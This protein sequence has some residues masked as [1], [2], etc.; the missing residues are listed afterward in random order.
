MTAL[1]RTDKENFLTH[2]ELTETNKALLFFS[3]L[4]SN[5]KIFSAFSFKPLML[6]LTK[7]DTKRLKLS[8]AAFEDAAKIEL[9]RIHCL[10]LRFHA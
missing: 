1:A 4:G 5:L 6:K 8:F 3:E 7:L 10:P 9:L 2:G